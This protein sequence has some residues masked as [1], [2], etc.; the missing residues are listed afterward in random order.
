MGK[1]VPVRI[2][3]RQTKVVVDLSQPKNHMVSNNTQI[4]ITALEV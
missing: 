3:K 4:L 2:I 1:T